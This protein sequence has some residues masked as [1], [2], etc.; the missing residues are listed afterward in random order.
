MED[1]LE[2]YE[3]LFLYKSEVMNLNQLILHNISSFSFIF[4]PLRGFCRFAVGQART[5]KQYF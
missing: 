2:V 4:E 3:R 5:A 1:F